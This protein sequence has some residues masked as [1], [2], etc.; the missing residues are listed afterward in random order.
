MLFCESV[1]PRLRM[2]SFTTLRAISPR[3][4]GSIGPSF[5]GT[6]L[7]RNLRSQDSQVL[8]RNTVSIAE[9]ISVVK[10]NHNNRKSH[11]FRAYFRLLELNKK[12]SFVLFT[13]V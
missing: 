12:C 10:S 6:D 1:T 3:R 13:T 9:N 5:Q 7:P 11:Y 4:L 8:L 2:R